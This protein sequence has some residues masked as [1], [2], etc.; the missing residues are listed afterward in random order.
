RWSRSAILSQYYSSPLDILTDEDYRARISRV[1]HGLILFYL[2]WEGG[3]RTVKEQLLNVLTDFH[4]DSEFQ[5]P[6]LGAL[7]CYDWPLV[8]EQESIREY[9]TVRLIKD[10]QI[11]DY[12]RTLTVKDLRSTLKLLQR[13]AVELIGTIK[14]AEDFLS[15]ETLDKYEMEQ[16]V[17]LFWPNLASSET[18]TFLTPSIGPNRRYVG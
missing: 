3:S 4:K 5:V 14:G 18:W 13:P 9:P 10:G 15:S 8:C 17:I 2:Q 6:F 7:D 12:R 16:N 1:Q 11:L